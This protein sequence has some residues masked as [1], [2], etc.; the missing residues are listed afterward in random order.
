[1]LRLSALS[2]MRL[3]PVIRNPRFREFWHDRGE[4]DVNHFAFACFA[5]KIRVET[6]LSLPVFKGSTFH[7]AFGHALDRISPSS[8][9]YF[10]K[11][12]P[13]SHWRAF[14]RGHPKPFLLI[15]PLEEKEHYRP[16]D[17]THFGLTLFGEAV[18]QFMI[19]FAALE[20]LGS[21]M[22]IG[23]KKA[24]FSIRSINQLTLREPL[25]LFHDNQWLAHP[26][27]L[28]AADIFQE[29]SSKADTVTISLTT[30]LRLKNNNRLVRNTP[31][32]RLFMERLL[33]RIN[34]L[35]VMWNGGSMINKDEKT[36]LLALAETVVTGRSSARWRDWTRRR[37]RNGRDMKFGGLLGE[38]TYVGEIDP[39]LPWLALGQWTG[40]G[41]K[42]SFGLGMYS[43]NIEEDTW[44]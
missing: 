14:G 10:Y 31:S 36:E 19:A 13:P 39:F 22:G 16:G 23:S 43:I 41:G 29:T 18:H 27:P 5:F 28:N 42:T 21:R 4:D 33:G 12:R 30:R 35:A 17:T 3:L 38:I 44:I 32:F 15:P 37:D 9:E 1:M 24:K 2:D 7:G 40:V 26:N 34:T 25:T 20:H 6:P 8:F 11:P